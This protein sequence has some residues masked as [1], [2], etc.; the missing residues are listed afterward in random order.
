MDL[1]GGDIYHNQI[2]MD[3]SVSVNPL[4]MPEG[5]KKALMDA[6]ENGSHYPDIYGTELVEKL[7]E[8][9]SVEKE[10]ILLGNGAAELIYA[11]VHAIYVQRNKQGVSALSIAPTFS[12]YENAI[13]AVG[14]NMEYV[15][16]GSLTRQDSADE[17]ESFDAQVLQ[18]LQDLQE[19]IS[20]HTDLVFLCNPN[21]PTSTIFERESIVQI[22]KRCKETNTILCVDECFLPFLIN[23]PELTMKAY[24]DEFQN[25]I[26]LRAFT[27]IYGIAGV[28]L[29]YALTSNE[30]LIQS[31]RAQL[32]PWN[33]SVLSQAAGV[34]ALEDKEFIAKT[35]QFI[36]K[37]KKYLLDA[38]EKLSLP[39]LGADAN[40]IFFKG[41]VDLSEKLLEYK[42][43]IR[44]CSNF[45]GLKKGYY[46]IGIR[47]HEENEKLMQ[48]VSEIIKG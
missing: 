17:I 24:M 44:D 36:E 34:A 48:V 20:D 28:R 7:A 30:I 27:K 29:G 3:F 16:P 14:G 38:F 13:Q 39:V 42:I 10:Q 5:V 31:M 47:T 11:L 37:E 33:T 41:P 23:E 32:Q 1:H 25:L 8:S 46:R 43:A 22:A 40:F 12:E 35:I 19:K 21:N 9:E 2:E 4:G 15:L 18:V 45:V 6:I 26:I